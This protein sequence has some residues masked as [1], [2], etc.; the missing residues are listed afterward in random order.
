[1]LFIL[2]SALVMIPH[3]ICKKFQNNVETSAVE[4]F[5]VITRPLRMLFGSCV[6]FPTKRN[7]GK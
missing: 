1:M 4:V 7:G 5:V 3:R 2:A 6:S